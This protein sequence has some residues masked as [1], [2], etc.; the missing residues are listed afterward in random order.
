MLKRKAQYP[1]ND[2]YILDKTSSFDKLIA[3]KPDE[4]IQTLQYYH[5][6]DHH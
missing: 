1:R 4:P 3:P 5:K 2:F 6:I